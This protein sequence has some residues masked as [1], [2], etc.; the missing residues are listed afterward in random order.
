M[1]DLSAAGKDARR[2]ELLNA[3]TELLAIN[4]AASLAEIAAY[5]KIGK[6]TLHRYFA[7]RDDLMLALGYRALMMV[8]E[9]I[10]SCH[11]DQDSAIEASTRIIEALV[12]LGDKLYF[13]I[14]ET[15]L[16]AHTEFRNAETNM[17][18]P[19]LALIKRGQASGELRADL[20]PEWILHM[21]NYA[22]YAAWHSLHDGYVARRDAPRLVITTMLS[23]IAAK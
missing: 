1:K 22:I 10:E 7:S 11:P 3:A 16:D 19:L 14:N 8:S 5:A 2:L 17:Q 20:T 6:A 13:L 15:I 12:P 4:P 9:A 18:A 21:L 23:G